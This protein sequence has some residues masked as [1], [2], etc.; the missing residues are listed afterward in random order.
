MFIYTHICF[1]SF[2]TM[3]QSFGSRWI[4]FMIYILLHYIISF[5]GVRI[6]ID[7]YHNQPHVFF[8]SFPPPL[9]WNSRPSTWWCVLSK[10]WFRVRGQHH[11]WR[12]R[13]DF[14]GRIFH[15]LKVGKSWDFHYLPGISGQMDKWVI[16]SFF[17]NHSTSFQCLIFSTQT[18]RIRVLFACQKTF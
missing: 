5:Y 13:S 1:N 2:Q 18:N 4:M 11:G 6:C 3:T 17:F 15:I 12:W 9:V 10:V 16:V 7:S 8:V 14:S